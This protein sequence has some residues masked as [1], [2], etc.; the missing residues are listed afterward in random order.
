[1]AKSNSAS[2]GA[3]GL[4]GGAVRPSCAEFTVAMAGS[5]ADRS[6]STDCS[7]LTVDLAESAHNIVALTFSPRQS[8]LQAARGVLAHG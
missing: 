5:A 2:A 3:D 7:A 6:G 4:A 1:M 8:R